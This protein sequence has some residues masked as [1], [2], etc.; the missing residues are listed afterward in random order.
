[1][2]AAAH[3]ELGTEAGRELIDRG[4]QMSFDEAV[5]F[6]RRGSG[7][8]NRS[9]SGWDA[10][11]PTERQ[12][13]GLVA[14]GQTNPQIADRLMSRATVK[15]HVSHCLTKL[16]MTTRAELAAGFTRRES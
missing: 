14:A 6:A 1:M 11:T 8:R 13:F 4:A 2:L 5:A 7:G 12:V 9:A 3:V 15:T 10:L 16:D